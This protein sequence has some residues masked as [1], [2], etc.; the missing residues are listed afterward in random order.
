MFMGL[1]RNLFTMQSNYKPNEGALDN[2]KGWQCQRSL[3]WYVCQHL[4]Y[5]QGRAPNKRTIN[6]S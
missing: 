1:L 6:S 3:G 4:T 5:W 2:D